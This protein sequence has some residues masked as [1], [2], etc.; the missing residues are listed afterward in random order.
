MKRI[1]YIEANRD[2]TIGGSYY[3]LFYLIQG[4]DR[5][6]YEPH[7]L[8][9]QDNPLMPKFAGCAASVRV[10][11]FRPSTSSPCRSLIDYAR[12]PYDLAVDV[13][14]KQPRINRIIRELRPD[15]VHLNN[16][17][18]SLHE[19]MLAC[20]L[21]GIPIISHDRGTGFPCSLR[22]KLFVRLLR[23][24]ISVSD[25]FRDN[26]VRQGLRVPVF[27]VYNGLD[28]HRVAS[29]LDDEKLATLKRDLGIQGKPVVL[30]MVGNVV[31]W[32]GQ[33]VVL[34]AIKRIVPEH[35]EIICVFAGS[36]ARGEESYKRELDDYV[37]ENRLEA[38]VRFTGYR[39]DIPDIL[40]V[41]DI[42]IHASIA[43]EPFGRVILEGMA[44][45]KPI[46][47][48]DSGGT[49]EQ[50]V[51]GETGLLVPMSDPEAMAAAMSRLLADLPAAREM[52][53][54]G[55]QRLEKEFSI[56]HMVAGVEE[57]YRGVFEK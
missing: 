23:A 16:G 57:I 5:S 28:V 15:L 41:V 44:A 4:L 53:R 48:T 18:A 50:I 56:E 1:L 19:W 14:F 11:D 33:M 51:E 13:I 9:C 39:S 34:Q 7:V 45:G 52:G 21:K 22:T 3:S 47:G 10:N 37:R 8:F 46:I 2:G 29:T 20:R 35:P 17:Y 27:R 49:P 42:L 6:K 25:S 32:K 24:I 38:H 30:G 43:P 36:V 40:Q 26:A 54:R 31:R 12:W 55:R